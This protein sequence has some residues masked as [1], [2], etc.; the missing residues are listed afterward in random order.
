MLR[1]FAFLALVLS[2]CTTAPAPDPQA[3]P[4]A[5]MPPERPAQLTPVE[6]VGDYAGKQMKLVIDGQTV[7]EGRGQ[8]LQPGQRWI[9]QVQPGSRPADLILDLEGCATYRTQVWRYVN[10]KTPVPGP[11]QAAVECWLKSTPPKT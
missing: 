10:S 1:A 9:L 6:F 7:F 2:A 4:A 5:P 8:L 3:A 11:V